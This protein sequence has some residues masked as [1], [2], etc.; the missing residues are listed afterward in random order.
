[1][2]AYTSLER[3]LNGGTC[4]VVELNNIKCLRFQALSGEQQGRIFSTYTIKANTTY[5]VSLDYYASSTHSNALKIEL[6]GGDYSWAGSSR[7]YSTLNQWERLSITIT[8]TSNTTLYIFAYA[9]K[10]KDAYINN[11]QLE[12]KDHATPY[13]SSNRAGGIC[14]DCSGYGN[15]G[16]ASGTFD[17]ST[18]SPRYSHSTGFSGNA[19]NRIT[20]TTTQFYYTDNFTWSCWIKHK[21]PNAASFAFTVGRADY[22]PDWG[23]GLQ[24]ISTS[25]V[26]L[27]FGSSD[28]AVSLDENNWHHLAFTKSGNNISIYVDGVPT[29]YTFSGTLPAYTNSQGLGIG[30]F[31][32][33]GGALYPFYGRLSDFRI[34][35]TAL[36]AAAVKELYQSS[37]SI[38]NNGTLQCSEIVEKDTNIEL[39][40]NGCI[41]AKNFTEIPGIRNMK[42]MMLPDGSSWARIYYLNL[43]ASD[44]SDYSSNDCFA[45]FNEA[46]YC[47]DQSNRFSL[48][49]YMHKFKNKNNEYEF[50][51][52][53][54][55]AST[56]KALPSYLELLSC[57]EN[58][59]GR[60]Q[61]N[62]GITT[63]AKW[64]FD[65]QFPDL[66]RPLIPKMTSNTEPSGTATAYGSYKES[67]LKRAYCAFDGHWRTG[68][69]VHYG[70]LYGLTTKIGYIFPAAQKNINLIKLIGYVDSNG[71]INSGVIEY[72]INGSD[73][74]TLVTLTQENFT[75]NEVCYY[76]V[77]VPELQG[78]RVGAISTSN[79]GGIIVR[80]LQVYEPYAGKRQLM[81]YSTSGQ[82]YWGVQAHGGYGIHE[83]SGLIG[84]Q[85]GERDL[86]IHNYGDNDEWYLAVHHDKTQRVRLSNTTGPSERYQIFAMGSTATS[87][88][89]GKCSAKL[90]SCRC[91]KNGIVGSH[92][93]PAMN[94][95]NG[96]VG[97]WD[98]IQ[99]STS[100]LSSYTFIPH[101]KSNIE[102]N[103]PSPWQ[104]NRWT[105]TNNID[106]AIT[107]TDTYQSLLTGMTSKE[108]AGLHYGPLTEVTSADWKDD[109]V[110]AATQYGWWSPVGQLKRYQG[111]IP[112]PNGTIQ[113]ET[114]LWVRIDTL[115]D[116]ELLSFFTDAI[117]TKEFYEL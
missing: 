105:Q 17:I 53:Y 92:Y 107:A 94:T 50:L 77:N 4:E 7:S 111:G 103:L 14:Y 54:P 87:S 99:G 78:I 101:K 5:T 34:Y 48:L 9:N 98:C 19:A 39:H 91:I 27:R 114:E 38:L 51:L 52:A 57:I 106:A 10:G 82:E 24:E 110:Y 29:N 58:Q 35:A 37:I 22:G 56:P 45:N 33:S 67:E 3:Q 74:S 65:I 12:E 109:T 2:G 20:N 96:N 76:H 44:S 59:N 86:V 80:E 47:I 108:D 117:Q 63:N 89:W 84:R 32:Y 93:L 60:N 1:M 28:Y 104:Y 116:P 102:K 72:T 30:C 31:W 113:L 70:S 97:L 64:E 15:H 75:N 13:T 11:I 42:T 55:Q 61:I 115:G 8:P 68:A 43:P 83:D 36:P 71:T 25:S 85:A 26:R 81:G 88:S 49:K 6:Y 95:N 40:Q 23:Y 62:T 16:T 18:N 73:W 21:Y 100:I 90:Y 66:K 41:K 69:D 79:D 112:A 46:H